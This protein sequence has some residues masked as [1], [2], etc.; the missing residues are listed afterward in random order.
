M[1]VVFYINGVLLD[2]LYR[3]DKFK[4]VKY[5]LMLLIDGVYLDFVYLKIYWEGMLVYLIS[6]Y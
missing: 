5:F 4:E 1:Y 3:R 6:M 2:W